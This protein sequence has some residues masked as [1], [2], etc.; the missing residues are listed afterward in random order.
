MA[1]IRPPAGLLDFSG[2]I[3][4][5]SLLV[6]LLEPQIALERGSRQIW[7]FPCDGWWPRPLLP[8]L[9]TQAFRIM[10]GMWGSIFLSLRRGLLTSL[11]CVTRKE[12][13][14]EHNKLPRMS[15]V[16]IE[17]LCSEG[18]DCCLLR[19][20]EIQ[21]AKQVSNSRSFTSFFSEKGGNWNC[22]FW[23]LYFD[24]VLS[25]LE[26]EGRWYSQSWLL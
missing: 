6:A 13:W 15:Q 2:L 16:L 17:H 9:V 5:E 24:C 18:R 25:R 4:F 1:L 10:E 8:Q 21:I 3:S 11:L 19:I 20:P 14:G 22:I 7:L 23:E 26:N 12:G